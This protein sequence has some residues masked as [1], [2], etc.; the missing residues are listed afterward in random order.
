MSAGPE[1]CHVCGERNTHSVECV[2]LGGWPEPQIQRAI[3]ARTRQR[4]LARQIW[5]DAGRELW[6]CC[7]F[8]AMRQTLE[9]CDGCDVQAI[10]DATEP[11]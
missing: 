3:N 4:F 5:H 6:L 1:T 7:A 2:D 10:L 8:A 9:W 11:E